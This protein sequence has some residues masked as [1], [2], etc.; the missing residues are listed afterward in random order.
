MTEN[1]HNPP[2]D[3]ANPIW[4]PAKRYGWGWGLPIAWQGW[5]VMAIWFVIMICGASFLAGG[6]WFAY[7]TFMLIMI[8]V[9]VGICYAKGESPRWRWGK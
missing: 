8:A 4:F 2:S 3:G 6:H 5:V 9:L 1:R 7:A